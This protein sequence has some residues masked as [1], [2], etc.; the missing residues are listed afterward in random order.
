VNGY[1]RALCAAANIEPGKLLWG[2][3]GKS[4][5]CNSKCPRGWVTLTKNSHITGQKRGCASGK[6]APLCAYGMIVQ[7]DGEMCYPTYSSHILSGGFSQAVDLEGKF[8]FEIVGGPAGG[9]GRFGSNLRR[10]SRR[11]DIRKRQFGGLNGGD[12]CGNMLAPGFLGI[13]VPAQ[14]SFMA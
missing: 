14:V 3:G 5:A 12:G 13:G 2:P 6:Y 10:R 8:D 9:P 4:K 1:Q 7:R 11:S